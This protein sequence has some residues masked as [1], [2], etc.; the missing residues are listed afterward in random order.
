MEKDIWEIY[1]WKSAKCAIIFF[2]RGIREFG[3]EGMN[4]A[5]TIT[6]VGNQ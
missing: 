5:V 4:G 1:S 6:V 3:K 2:S